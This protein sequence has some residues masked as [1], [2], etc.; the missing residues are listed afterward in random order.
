MQLTVVCSCGVQL[1]CPRTVNF[2]AMLKPAASRACHKFV[3]IACT[4][5]AHA[6]IPG[7]CVCTLPGHACNVH[8]RGVC[9]SVRS[10]PSAG[11]HGRGAPRHKGLLPL[12]LQA[13]NRLSRPPVLLQLMLRNTH[14]Q[15]PAQQPLCPSAPDGGNPV[16]KLWC[17][18]A[19]RPAQASMGCSAC[20]QAFPAASVDPRPPRARPAVLPAAG[21]VKPLAP[22]AF[23]PPG[24]PAAAQPPPPHRAG[25]GPL[26]LQALPPGAVPAPSGQMAQVGIKQA[27]C[28]EAARGML[29]AEQVLLGLSVRTL[30]TRAAHRGRTC[31]VC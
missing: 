29:A 17:C 20:S 4:V 5:G 31:K 12:N 21:M 13:S 10:Q 28:A 27:P 8:T 3:A 23:A 19:T 1:R 26:G 18:P 2:S 25:G 24:F 6:Y 16:P 9:H 15:Q 30:C 7:S 11:M 22:G 14:W